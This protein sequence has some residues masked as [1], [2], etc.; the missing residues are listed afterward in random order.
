M[1]LLTTGCFL[2][3]TDPELVRAWATFPDPV[4]ADASGEVLEYMGTSRTPAATYRHV[5][6]HRCVPATQQ[7]Q[8][9]IVPARQGWTPEEAV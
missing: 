2:H 8:R 5:F 4:M 6:R 3:A 1:T 7:P 9:W